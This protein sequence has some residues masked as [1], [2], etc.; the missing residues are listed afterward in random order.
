LVD[1][2]VPATVPVPAADGVAVSFTVV[3]VVCFVVAL[4]VVCGLGDG[5]RDAV[6]EPLALAVGL[7]GPVPPVVL[8]A[9][10]AAAP[11]RLGSAGRVV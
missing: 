7:A 5:F 3:A 11:D 4:A 2:D 6:T 8:A 9:G 1:A 10:R